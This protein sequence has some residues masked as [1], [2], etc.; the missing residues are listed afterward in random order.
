MGESGSVTRARCRRAN[1]RRRPRGACASL[2]RRVFLAAAPAPAAVA[3]PVKT[4][5]PGELASSG[6]EG[7]RS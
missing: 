4:S 5:A 3:E 2:Q 1:V 6:S 7:R